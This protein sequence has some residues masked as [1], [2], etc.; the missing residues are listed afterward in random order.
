[1]LCEHGYVTYK[2][3]YKYLIISETRRIFKKY[4]KESILFVRIFL[5]TP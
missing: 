4:L 3:G 2:L 5:N 1:M